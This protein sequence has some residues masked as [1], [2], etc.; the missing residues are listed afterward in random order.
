MNIINICF[1]T[2]SC[3]AIFKTAEIVPIF[4]SGNKT[5]CDNYRPIALISNIAKIFE[6]V[7]YNR[8]V[9]FTNKYNII[10]DR[11][12]G[13]SKN[14]GCKDAITFLFYRWYSEHY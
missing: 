12:F 2:G 8:L 11:Q 5:T 13:F 14:L 3:P 9:E 10:N 6:T 7:L 1:E 4:K